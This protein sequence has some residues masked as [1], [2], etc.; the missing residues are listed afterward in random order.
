LNSGSEINREILE[1]RN[2]LSK[3]EKDRA[4]EK[5]QI[6]TRLKALEEGLI[7]NSSRID[8]LMQRSPIVGE[9]VEEEQIK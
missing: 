2:D 9:R 1:L 7:S 6:E 4:N 3:L 5:Q 8:E